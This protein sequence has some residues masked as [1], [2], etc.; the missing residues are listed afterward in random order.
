LVNAYYPDRDRGLRQ[1]VEA[2]GTNLL[3]TAAILELD[4]FLPDV[5]H[6]V[7]KKNK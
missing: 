6:A 7:H 5:I 4:E 2:Y 1:S 3:T